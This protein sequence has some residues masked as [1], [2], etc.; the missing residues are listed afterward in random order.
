MLVSVPKVQ[1]VSLSHW[2]IFFIGGMDI[3]R[4]AKN[5]KKGC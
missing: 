3:W 4:A 2:G 5:A 1:A